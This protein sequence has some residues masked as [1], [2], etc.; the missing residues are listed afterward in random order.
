MAISNSGLGR[1]LGSLIPQKSAKQPL[2]VRDEHDE[3]VPYN[4]GVLMISP[5]EVIAN[6]FQPRHKFTDYK[7]DELAASI[8]EHGII[9][10][11]IVGSK[12]NGKYELIA[13][14]RRL[15]ASKL[16]GLKEVPVVIKDVADQDKLE[17]ALIENIQR[18]DLNPIDCAMSYRRLID[19]FKLTQE[20]VAKKVG[21]SR[22]VVANT[23]RFLNLPEEI[24]L[25]L[26]DGK[27]TEGHAKYIIGIEG[28]VKQMKLFRQILHTGLTVGDTSTEVRKMGGTKQ[29]RVKI[30]YLDK[31]KEFA[32]REFFSA[33]A[34]IK[35]SGKG[36]QIVVHFYSDEEL[37]GL[38]DKIKNA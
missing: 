36:G 15:R 1:G 21:K 5:D 11:L 2:V 35:R 9:Q 24:K 14:E 26:I 25:A 28:E 32:I 23:L 4:G 29:A 34:E 12:K 3:I 27:I 8:R 20:D 31:D 6:V 33:K 22:P 30:N 7:L 17:L 10:P 13:G 38:M 37:N 18:E 16:A 19:E